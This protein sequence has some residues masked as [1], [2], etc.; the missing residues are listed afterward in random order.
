MNHHRHS[1]PRRWR[2]LLLLAGLLLILAL[3]LFW[4]RPDLARW[5]LSPAAITA[6]IFLG[7]H[8]GMVIGVALF[9]HLARKRW[10]TRR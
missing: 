9:A 1:V 2:K 3:T 7:V 6:A 5:L 8:G 10:L 4:L